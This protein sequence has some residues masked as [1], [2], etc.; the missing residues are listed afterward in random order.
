MNFLVLGVFVGS[1]VYMVYNYRLSLTQPTE[2]LSPITNM[3]FPMMILWSCCLAYFFAFFGISFIDTKVLAESP[4][5]YGL[6]RIEQDS[7]SSEEETTST[8]AASSS[9]ATAAA[10]VQALT[11]SSHAAHIQQFVPGAG[12]HTTTATHPPRSDGPICSDIQPKS[13]APTTTTDAA[14]AGAAAAPAGEATTPASSAA[15]AADVD[16]TAL[17][18]EEVLEHLISGTLKDYQLE[19]KL[20][21]YER[22]VGVRRSLYEHVLDK[23]LS[24][25]PYTGYDYG[26]VF[27]ANCEI[28]IGYVPIPVGIVG[29]LTINGEALYIPMA[30]TEGCLVASTNRGCKAISV[31]GGCYSV[32]MKDAITRAPCV[33]M[34]SAMRAAALKRWV[35]VPENYLQLEHAFNSTTNYGKL[36]GVEATVAGRNVYLRFNCMSGDAMGM[37]MVSKGCLKAIEVL[38]GQFP[39]LILVA[40]SGNMC[41][42]K[43]PAA[44]NWILGRGKSIVVEAVIPESVVK[45][46][47]KS[48]VYDMIETN[49]QKNHI[50]SAMAGSV[51]GFNAH[52]ANIVTAVFLATGQD[53]AQNVESSNCLTIMEYA[54]DMRSL[55]VSV[56]MPS[57]EVG[58]V[59]GGTH[60][61]AQAGCL[62]ICGVRG[63]A[64]GPGSL[65]GDNARKLAQIVGSAVLAGELSLM[66]ALAANHLVNSHM[67]H[68][69]KPA[70][71]PAVTGVADMGGMRKNLSMPELSTTSK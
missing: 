8:A 4:S 10:A 28:V 58:T 33:R 51:G 15:A 62:E 44:I 24:L 18:D 30:T 54:E 2:S 47:L 68:N 63:A 1:I 42:D 27:G 34:P 38:E 57:I 19:K 46:V 48:S 45:S 59:G 43:K 67:Q 6:E 39:D 17:T 35:G 13:K 20:G 21:D 56:T 32:V 22:A 23:D 53:P 71:V 70:E 5:T 7:D 65:P 61:P 25:I 26:K 69:R 16:Y 40:I 11:P 14:G 49:K 55:H 29:P 37:N 66:A 41:T 36:A 50:G 60:L 52:A 31:S 9:A 64:K 3:F 12:F